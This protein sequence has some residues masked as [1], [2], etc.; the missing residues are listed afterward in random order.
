MRMRGGYQDVVGGQSAL[1]RSPALGGVQDFARNHATVT[2][3]DR[4][5]GLAVIEDKAASVQFIVNVR[6]QAVVEVAIDGRAQPRGDVAG[7]C[8][9]PELARRAR[10]FLRP[11]R[12]RRESTDRSAETDPKEE[13]REIPKTGRSHRFIAYSSNC[14]ARLVK[15]FSGTP[16]LNSP[17]PLVG[18]AC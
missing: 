16:R 5:P 12:L 7:G 3:H 1:F 6:G 15:A 13:S 14:P 11:D 18:Q 2:H 17:A 9:R 4:Q 10:G 8:A